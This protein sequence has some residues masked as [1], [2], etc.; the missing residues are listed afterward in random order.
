MHATKPLAIGEGAILCSRDVATVARVA[1]VANFGFDEERVQTGALGLNAKL[2]EWH[3]ATALA[4][5]D[6]L[7]DVLAGRR[8]AAARLRE[9]LEPLGCT[10]QAGCEGS[11]WQFVP[12]LA[13]TPAARDAVVA[14]A[15]D[16]VELR[17]YFDPPLHRLGALAD[18]PVHGSLA[19]TDDLARRILSLPMANDLTDAELDSIVAVVAAALAPVG[20]GA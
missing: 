5:L 7:P 16:D 10:F 18:A 9:A 6:R 8:R 14:A 13:P 3:C 4:A 11:P 2:D 1:S 20:G 12:V 19:T 15:A 17:T